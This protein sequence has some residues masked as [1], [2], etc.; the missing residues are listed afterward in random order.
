M[1]LQNTMY[2]REGICTGVFGLD[3][4]NG[5]HKAWQVTQTQKYRRFGSTGDQSPPISCMVFQLA[6]ILSH[7][8]VPATW[9]GDR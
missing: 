2:D 5:F 6:Q 9:L 4:I 8:R 7:F 3:V 1:I